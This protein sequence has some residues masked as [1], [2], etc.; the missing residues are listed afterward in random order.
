ME[1]RRRRRIQIHRDLDGTL[2]LR[3]DGQSYGG[4]H[5]CEYHS[6]G[7]ALKYP[8]ESAPSLAARQVVE[9]ALCVEGRVELGTLP[10]LVASRSG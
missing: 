7:L 3:I 10:A 9:I 6:R 8:P 2:E 1:R 5:I 4:G